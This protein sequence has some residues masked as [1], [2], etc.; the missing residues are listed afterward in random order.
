MRMMPDA[1]A[2][3]LLLPLLA[4]AQPRAGRTLDIY[5]I[6][7]EGGQ[8][9]LYMTPSGQSVLVDTGNPGERDSGR[10]MATLAEAGVT[11]LDFLVLTHYHVDHV[12]GVQELAK[13]MPIRHFVDHGP[14]VEPNEQVPGFQQAYA[15]LYRRASHTVVKAGDTLPVSGL[16]WYIVS[17]G[18]KTITTALPGAGLLN[19][20]C[21]TFNPREITR[22]PENDQSVGSV[23]VYGR[24]RT[25]NLADLL[26]NS[27]A[28]LMCPKNLLGTADLYL[29]SHHG[30]S[31]SGSEAL[32]HG[33]RP[34]VAVMNN[35]SR[36][37]GA[38]QTFQTLHTSPGLEDLWLLHWSYNG[39]IEHNPPGV[40]IANVDDVQTIA[41]VIT[42]PPT[43]RTSP[44]GPGAG[45]PP[46]GAP[47][48]GGG[49][50]GGHTGPAYLIKVSAQSDGTFTVTN[51][52]NGFSKTYHNRR[53]ADSNQRP[54]FSPVILSDKPTAERRAVR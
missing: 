53:S 18:G 20:A 46:G 45:S 29:T 17:S 21:A 35:G 9:T 23:I 6:D 27:E 36:K 32:V 38:V 44:G 13:Q 10:I 5:F 48:P 3:A 4:A 49:R 26:W 40:F 12:G 2:L 51:T 47:A 11:S 19:P 39:G 28:N 50:S 15:E 25:V 22:D 42:A 54:A 33:L 1:A 14:T 34:R 30:L 37:G 7:T 31:E 8:S 52:R 43:Q 16:E 41:A 24:F